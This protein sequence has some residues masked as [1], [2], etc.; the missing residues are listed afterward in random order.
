MCCHSMTHGVNVAISIRLT[1]IHS[2]IQYHDI[3]TE[4]HHL[5]C[6]LNN[7]MFHKFLMQIHTGLQH[8]IIWPPQPHCLPLT[9]PTLADKLKE[10]GYATHAVGKWHLGIYKKACWPT[11]RGFDSYFGKKN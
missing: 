10:A 9:D 4:F 7:T 5:D 8:G 1:N 3:C 2:L 6:W 11:Q